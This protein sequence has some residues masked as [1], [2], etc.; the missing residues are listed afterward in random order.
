M[1]LGIGGK[2]YKYDLVSKECHFEFSSYARTSLQLYDFDD[3]L[4]AAQQDQVRLWDFF[5]HKEEVPELVTVLEA[6]LKI[7][8]LKVNKFAEQTGERKGEFYYVISAKDEFKVYIGRMEL[9]LEG[10]ID[11]NRDSIRCIEYGIDMKLL[12]IGTE[13]G[14]IFTFELPSRQEV[15]QNDHNRYPRGKNNE[16]P[17]AI[18]VGE[19]KKAHDKNDYDYSVTLLYRITAF[20]EEDFFAMHVK[21][22]GLKIWNQQTRQ[23]HRV[24]VPE[25]NGEIDNIRATPD[26]R[27]LVVG[28]ASA[29]IIRF[30]RILKEEAQLSSLDDGKISVSTKHS[31][32]SIHPIIFLFAD[33]VHLFRY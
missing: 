21:H 26:G 25:Y 29:G 12:Y 31:P 7:E 5:D 10:D 2:V 11:D 24:E 15:E 6:P 1:Y 16:P 20:L 30:Y 8:C 4:L 3:K 27:F 23:F 14:K 22:A 19:P 28:F 13:K 9:L 32:Q 17:R 33:G 18:V